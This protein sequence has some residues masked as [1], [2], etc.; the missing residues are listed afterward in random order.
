[1]DIIGGLIADN[2]LE[3][4][5]GQE[6]VGINWADGTTGAISGV[7]VTNTG[8]GAQLYGLELANN[9][10]VYLSGDNFSG[11]LNGGNGIDG[12]SQEVSQSAVFFPNQLVATKS[13]EQTLTFTAGAVAVQNLHIQATGDFAQTNGCST[14]L[15]P[16]G[17]C[18]IQVTFTP[19][20]VG[21]R[22]GSITI[23][24]DAPNSP[25]TVSFAGTGLSFGLGFVMPSGSSSSA[26]VTP[27]ATA[28]YTLSIGGAGVSGTASLSCI[29]APEGATCNVVGTQAVSATTARDLMVSVTTTSHTR[30]AVGRKD[31]RP[32]PWASAI[33][34]MGWVALPR[35]GRT[36][37]SAHRHDLLP[38]L[39][40]MSLCSC[41]GRDSTPPGK[42]TLIV[43]A[44]VGNASA[45]IP[46][47]LTVR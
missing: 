10:G 6:Q 39:L 3:H 2:G 31:F 9:P 15:P 5:G 1:V 43:T 28:N 46:L 19:S 18:K 8:V 13:S 42:Y 21:A 40:L 24:D 23:T 11:N 41:G 35:R 32:L 30:G 26:T 29:G 14:D 12:Q 17:T 47:T 4:L 36:R 20:V 7:T 16:Y 34:L 22:N 25:Q 45:R 37:R 38:L 33:V 27:G 44:S